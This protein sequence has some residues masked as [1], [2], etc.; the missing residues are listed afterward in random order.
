[1]GALGMGQGSAVQSSCYHQVGQ[2]R[3]EEITQL[4]ALF[5]CHTW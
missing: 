3:S 1:M 2:V 4:Q 5:F